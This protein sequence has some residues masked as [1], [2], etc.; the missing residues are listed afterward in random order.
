MR[1][2]HFA[3]LATI[4]FAFALFFAARTI[5]TT[6]QFS[7]RFRFFLFFSFFLQLVDAQDEIAQQE[8]ARDRATARLAVARADGSSAGSNSVSIT[9]SCRDLPR[10]EWDTKSDPLCALFMRNTAS[11]Y[12]YV[13]QTE[14]LRNDPDPDFR[15]P[16]VIGDYDGGDK[17]LKFSVYDYDNENDELSEKDR[18][19]SAIVVSSA[20]GLCDAA[21]LPLY[22]VHNIEHTKRVV[23]SLSTFIMIDAS[24]R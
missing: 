18:I 12:E 21:A 3:L 19:G 6:P 22:S 9:V 1:S 15:K 13:D 8:S 17:Q 23:Y 16:V 4:S 24:N 7:P 2:S 10:K 20:S 11:E 5:L 14:W